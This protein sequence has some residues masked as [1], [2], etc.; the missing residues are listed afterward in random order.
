MSLTIFNYLYSYEINPSC[1]RAEVLA[2]ISSVLLM[3]ISF[4]SP[5]SSANKSEPHRLDGDQG[6]FI[7]DK[8]N[9]YIRNEIGWGSQLLLTATPA[10]TMLIYWDQKVILRRGILGPGNFIPQSI[11]NEARKK[12]GLI[13]MANTKLYPKRNEFDSILENIPSLLIYP[14]AERGWVILGGSSI[15]CFSKSDEKWFVGWSDKLLELLIK[16]E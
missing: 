12:N 10:A 4:L 8:I 15:R 16:S 7:D 6:I 9:N 5:S 13:S 1:Q 3:L 2:A 11:C 14:L